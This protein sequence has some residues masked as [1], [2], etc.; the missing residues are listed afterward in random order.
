MPGKNK[1]SVQITENLT[2]TSLVLVAVLAIPLNIVIF[3]ALKESEYTIVRFIPPA[4]SILVGILAFFRKRISFPFKMISF[5]ILLF[6]GGIFTLMLGLIDMSGLWFLLAV[7]YVLLVSGKRDALIVLFVTIILI[8]TGGFLIVTKNSFI[9]LNYNFTECEFACIT[10][11][12]LHFLLLSTIIFYIIHTI[13]IQLKK[14]NYELKQ[15]TQDLSEINTELQLRIQEKKKIKQKLVETVIL[16]EEKE[17]KR[18]ASDLHDGLGPVLSAINLYFQA[19][20]D[21]PQEDK[22]SI[23]K[24]LKEIIKNAVEDISRISHNISPQILET[25]GLIPA[26]KA[27]INQIN[28]SGHIK[29]DLNFDVLNRFDLK[30]EMSVYRAVTE[31]INNT[32]KHAEASVAEIKIMKKNN[33]LIIQY[34][35]NGIGFDFDEKTKENSGLGLK[36]I[37]NRITSLDGKIKFEKYLKKGMYAEIKIPYI[38]IKKNEKD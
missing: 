18:I 2:D 23:E 31:L 6:F 10:A 19:Y 37:K 33:H 1:I 28:I 7:I 35:D 29:F 27:F 3:F 38:E 20:I 22:S 11:R 32:I 16:T 13:L 24:T 5:I 15:K 26:L 30:Y 34:S 9:P 4:L 14:N 17:R 12:I 21:A 25:Y 36:N 8:S